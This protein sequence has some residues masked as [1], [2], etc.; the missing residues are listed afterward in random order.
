MDT[1]TKLVTIANLDRVQLQIALPTVSAATVR[2]GLPLQF[3]V[4][5]LPG[6]TFRGTIRTIGIQADPTNGTIA[7]T[8]LIDNPNHLLKSDLFARVQIVIARHSPATL[9]A[10]AAL[11][12]E[13][14]TDGME[15]SVLR[16]GKDSVLKKTVVKTGFIHGDVIEIVSG[17]RPGDTVATTGGYGLPDGTRV[18]VATAGEAP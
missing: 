6:R 3:T 13:I 1:A 9:L 16:L 2:V 11:M 7:A 12:Q 5:S 10:R 8:A 14:T 17:V 15:N 18:S 4:D